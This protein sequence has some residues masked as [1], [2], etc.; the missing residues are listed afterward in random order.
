MEKLELM[1]QMVV[2]DLVHLLDHLDHLDHLVAVAAAD[3][4]VVVDPLDH[5][6]HLVVVD[7]SVKDISRD[8]VSRI[9]EVT[10]IEEI[11]ARDMEV[12]PVVDADHG[13]IDKVI[14]TDLDSNRGK[15]SSKD[16]IALVDLAVAVDQVVP[17]DIMAVAALAV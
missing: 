11:G 3:Q 7:N 6:D 17:L 4:V 16:R 5:L 13:R 9:E 10:E 15:A 1:D 14:R 2:V 12:G 8:L